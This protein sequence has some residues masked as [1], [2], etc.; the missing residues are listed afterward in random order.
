MAIDL[1]DVRRKTRDRPLD[2]ASLP[3]EPMAVLARW[4][5]DATEAQIA[6][7]NAMVISTVDADGQPS[8]RT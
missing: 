8:A 6:E 1:A 2:E 4:F 7:P 3:P 5:D